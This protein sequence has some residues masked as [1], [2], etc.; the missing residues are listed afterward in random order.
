MS[1][2]G[3]IF[4]LAMTIYCT[5][6]VCWKIRTITRACL[7][8]GGTNLRDLLAMLVESSALY[9]SWAMFYA[10]THQI[11]DNS[12]L[13]AIAT[14][15]PIAGIANALLY[16]RV[17]MV[18]SSERDTIHPSQALRFRTRT[19]QVDLDVLDSEA[20]VV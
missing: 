7:P 10:I 13:F 19:G 15:P 6:G 16:T 12:Q 2:T 18:A 14:L 8:E 11:N 4:T 1:L 20:S 3:F 17:G 5:L 9:T